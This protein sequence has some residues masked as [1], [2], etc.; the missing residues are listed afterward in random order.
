MVFSVSWARQVSLYLQ[1]LS[2]SMKGLW[3]YPTVKLTSWPAS[4]MD[5]GRRHE[6][7]RSE[8]KNFITLSSAIR[9]NVGIFVSIMLAPKSYGRGADRPR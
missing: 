8:T 3:S 2:R 9:M 1:L 6:T 7:F 4:F 5:T